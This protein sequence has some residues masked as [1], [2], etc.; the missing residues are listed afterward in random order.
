MG[1][2]IKPTSSWILVG[3]LTAE[4][5]QNSQVAFLIPSSNLTILQHSSTMQL[6]LRP[7]NK[8]NVGLG[9]IMCLPLFLRSHARCPLGYLLQVCTSTVT[10]RPFSPV[11]SWRAHHRSQ[12]F[13]AAVHLISPTGGCLPTPGLL[14]LPPQLWVFRGLHLFTSVSAKVSP[15]L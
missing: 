3:F 11:R 6:S 12:A 15:K 5:G 9:L 8:K 1:P 7:L 13:S 2:G 10:G 14:G 4:P